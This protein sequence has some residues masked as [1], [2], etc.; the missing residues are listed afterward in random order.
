MRIPA[1]P[2]AVP[3]TVAGC[4]GWF[5]PAGGLPLGAGG[6]PLD[7]GIIL[8]GPEGHEALLAHRG[9]RDLAMRCAALGL[10]TLRMDHPGAGDSPGDRFRLEAARGAI[11]GAMDWM[12]GEAG[13]ATVALA[14]LRLGALLAAQAAA[15]RPGEV[16]ALLLLAP[17]AQGRLHRRQM[18][19]AAAVGGSRD[20]RAEGI[21]VAGHP[22]PAEELD[23]L[24]S[25]DLSAALC[26]AAVPRVLV[27]DREAGAARR[28]APTVAFEG[29]EGLD[30]FLLP[31]H[32]ARLPVAAFARA[33]AWLAE[34][35]GPALAA[36][37][38]AEAEPRPVGGG[39]TERVL[40]FGPGGSLA[41]VLCSPAPALARRT[42]A[43]LLNTGGNSHVGVGRFG[44]RL[45]RRLAAAGIPSLRMD[46]PGLG[47]S[48]AAE[49][50]DPAMPPDPFGEGLLPAARAGRDALA[51]EGASRCLAIGLCSGAHVALRLAL[52]DPRID[53]LALF[54][55]PAF[56]R[57]QGGAPAL[58]GGPPPGEAPWLRRPRMAWRRL[59]AEADRGLA[60]I[61]I[62]T[63]LDAPA[64]WMR[65]LA[66]RRVHLL[67][68]YSRGDRGLRELRAHF[69]RRGRRLAAL[70]LVR[71]RVLDGT[72]HTLA[73]LAMQAEA[74]GLVEE[75]ALRLDSAA[76]P[77]GAG[78]PHRDRRAAGSLSD[79]ALPAR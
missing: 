51:A 63:G 1:P 37:V 75:I 44:V 38:V 22:W 69:G 57:S 10:P 46:L 12:R 2:R 48:D 77:V 41:G 9:L 49:G 62:E 67:L 11:L 42:A 32:E 17:V 15:R 66:A 47:D 64:A 29:F 68:G 70:P 3:V 50:T 14:G 55:L 73:P 40:R 65:R 5:H 33:G 13:C 4:H 76:A 31:A 43:L 74:A 78:T 7:R 58:D 20:D 35:A 8:V 36:P 59:K 18:L 24:A 26:R 54:N 45:A 19:L 53:G 30:R 60:A 6:Q 39:A 23:D 72:E 34:G 56:D 71:C 79:L 21:E 25:G 28:V 61:G 27:M 52:Q 16:A